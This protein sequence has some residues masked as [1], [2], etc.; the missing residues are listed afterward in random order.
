[1]LKITTLFFLLFT[2]AT[3]AAGTPRER[4]GTIQSAVS[5]VNTKDPLMGI[6]LTHQPDILTRLMEQVERDRKFGNFS[7]AA[8]E[9]NDLEFLLARVERD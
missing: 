4:I 1:M 7:R 3:F 9:Q 5:E 8:V 6:W 2:V